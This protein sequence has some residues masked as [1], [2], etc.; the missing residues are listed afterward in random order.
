MTLLEVRDLGFAYAARSTPVLAS[1]SASF[2]EGAITAVTGP[3]GAGKSTL[4][5][6]LGL[7]LRPSSGAVLVGGRAVSPLSDAE[8]SVIRS[9]TVGFVFQDALLDRSRSALDNVLE[10]AVFAGVRRAAV[11]PRAREL[12]ER[13][14]VAHR[15]RHRPGQMSGGQAQRVALCR[16]LLLRPRIVLGDEPTGNLDRENA[17]VVWAVLAGEAAAGVTVV[18]ATHDD[19][20]VSRADHR[21]HL[22]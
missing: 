10:P 7:L 20:L 11:E 16:A 12:L 21:V 17:E 19:V 5:Y 2:A 6:L 4:L 9:R 14:G 1:V 22:A 3:S 18:V 13:M 15:A 8:R